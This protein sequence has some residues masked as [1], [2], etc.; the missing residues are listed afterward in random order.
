MPDAATVRFVRSSGPG[1]QSVNKLSTKAELRLPL[2]TLRN[3]SDAALSRLRRFAGQRLTQ[4]DELLIQAED[5]RSQRENRDACFARL[6]TLV[7]KAAT[8]PKKRKKT[9]PGRAARERRLKQKKEQGEKKQRRQWRR[10]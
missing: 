5:S 4:N 7:I 2:H 8:L 10:D 1:G 9:R 3:I 6:R